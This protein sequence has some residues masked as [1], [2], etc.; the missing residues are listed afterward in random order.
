M[1]AEAYPSEA[2]RPGVEVYY[3]YQAGCD[4][5]ECALDERGIHLGDGWSRWWGDFRDTW[6]EA[7]IDA[8]AHNTEKHP[9][10]ALTWEEIIHGRETAD[11]L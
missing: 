3:G 4:A 8:V 5:D 11:R 2:M 10:P 6:I 7:R 1:T 9:T